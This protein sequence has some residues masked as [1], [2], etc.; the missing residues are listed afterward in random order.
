M[1]FLVLIT[2]L[3]CCCCARGVGGASAASA[4]GLVGDTANEDVGGV[5]EHVLD[6][7]VL[8][9]GALLLLRAGY[10]AG[11][12]QLQAALLRSDC[13]CRR[14]GFASPQSSPREE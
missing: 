2:P 1:C 13:G 10:L 9:V 3:R 6:E 12:G 11:G 4:G 7:I 8:V 14:R 5:A